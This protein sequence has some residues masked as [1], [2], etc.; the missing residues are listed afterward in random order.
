MQNPKG[1]AAKRPRDGAH[2]NALGLLK[3]RCTQ[4]AP[5]PASVKHPL[6]APTRHR[7]VLGLGVT[8][9]YVMT[10][11]NMTPIGKELFGL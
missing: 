6:T 2:G 3:G 10:T 5:K 8:K 4:L 9:S 7:G 11:G 1:L